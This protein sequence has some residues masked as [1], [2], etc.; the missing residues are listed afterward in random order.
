[1]GNQPEVTDGFAPKGRLAPRDGRQ[2]GVGE[3]H[4][5]HAPVVGADA[6]ASEGSLTFEVL[7]ER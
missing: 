1:V 5:Q 3:S 2:Q 7:E 6:G 4:R